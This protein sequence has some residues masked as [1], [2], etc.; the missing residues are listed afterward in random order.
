M[1]FGGEWRY[2]SNPP[3]HPPCCVV[4][5]AALVNFPL[6][7]ASAIG[8]SGFKLNS[9]KTGFLA[10]YLHAMGPPY[11]GVLATWGGMT[12]AR[13]SIFFGTERGKEMIKTV[14]ITGPFAG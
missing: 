6:W 10:S 11:K 13:F 8:Q 3:A 4:Q 7:K 2:V 9:G 14:G 12:F 1:H 5:L